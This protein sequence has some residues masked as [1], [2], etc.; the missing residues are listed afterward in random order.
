MT[1][2]SSSILISYSEGKTFHFGVK[3]IL[4]APVDAIVN[5][6]NSGLSHGGGLAAIIS[7]EAGPEL[8]EECGRIISKF[9]RI[10]ET[11]AVPTKAY[12]LPFKSVIHAVGPRM[13]VGDEQIKIENAITNSLLVA[14]KKGWESVA[15]PAIST[16]VFGVPK[17]ICAYAF[18]NAIPSFW[19][20][21]KDTSVNLV[22]LCLIASDFMAFK[23]VLQP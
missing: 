23:N 14:D 8:D 13:G 12:N 5:P 4:S 16:G 11:F 6:A 19:E 15:F 7:R 2:N 3:D 1:D 10:K 9:G 20:T 21:Y 17:E 18:K 22:W